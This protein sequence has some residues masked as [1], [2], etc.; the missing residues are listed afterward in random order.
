MKIA[1]TILLL[2]SGFVSFSQRKMPPRKAYHKVDTILAKSLGADEYGMRKY[3]MC[4]LKTGPTKDLSPD[5]AKKIQVLHLQN[6]SK[7]ASQ[8]KL[9]V[10]GPFLDNTELEG[11]I[12]FNVETVQE[13]KTLAETDP[14]VKAGLLVMEFHPWY[15]SAALMQVNL[16]HSKIQK[17][18][19]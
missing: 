13:A 1:L 12:V 16:I 2:L 6:I 14:A 8:G 15:C 18:S 7:L 3:V 4:F 17:K 11:V 5:S 9:C 19:F 10:A